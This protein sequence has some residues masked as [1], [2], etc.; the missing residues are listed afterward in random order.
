MY[1]R[2][3]GPVFEKKKENW[4]MLNNNEIYV[5]VK[6]THYNRD[7]KVKWIMLV[8]AC[9]ENGRKQNSQKGSIY[10]FGNNEAER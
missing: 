10:E 7:N 6:K 9:T 2:I 5:M 8:W 4:R 3:L 1:R